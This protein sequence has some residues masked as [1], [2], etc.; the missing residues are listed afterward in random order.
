VKGEGEQ[1]HGVT[2]V[3]ARL[4]HD[5]QNPDLHVLVDLGPRA[6]LR[7]VRAAIEDNVVQHARQALSREDLPTLVHYRLARGSGQRAR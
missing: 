5:P 6:D 3:S 2:A 1:V 4:V 7:E